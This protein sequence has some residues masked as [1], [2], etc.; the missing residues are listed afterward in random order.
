MPLTQTV[1]PAIEPITLA[2]AK[3]QARVIDS[4]EDALLSLMIGSARRYAEAHCGRSFIT[5]QW[6]LTLDSFPGPWAFGALHGKTFSLPGHAIQVER[7]PLQSVQAITY[8]DMQGAWQ[9]MPSTDYVVDTTSPVGRIVPV[10]GVT[11]PITQPQIASVRV[12]FTAGYGALAADVP[13][14][15]RQWLLIRVAG[16]YENREEVA[17]QRYTVQPV[18]FIDRL[19]DPYVVQL[20]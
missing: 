5:Q 8:R 6:R 18:A 12:D 15:I 10:F 14:G 1:A 16:L 13:E 3:L 19:L 2:E 7:S 9:T 11:W 20:A 17:A 4:A